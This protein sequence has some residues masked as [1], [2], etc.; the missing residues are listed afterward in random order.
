M[1]RIVKLMGGDIVVDSEVGVG[2]SIYI[3]LR[4]DTPAQDEEPFSVAGAEPLGKTLRI[5][6]LPRTNPSVVLPYSA[7]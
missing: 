1:K 7:Y 4:L 3:N 2:T 6:S 5:Y